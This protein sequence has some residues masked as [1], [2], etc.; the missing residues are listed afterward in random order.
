MQGIEFEALIL[1]LLNMLAT[2]RPVF[3][4]S[5][6]AFTQLSSKPFSP[7]MRQNYNWRKRPAVL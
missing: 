5:K 6:T 4:A 7:R 3:L 2:D 1:C